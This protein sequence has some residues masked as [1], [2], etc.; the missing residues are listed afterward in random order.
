MLVERD[1]QPATQTVENPF[2][3]VSL[4]ALGL[5][6][7]IRPLHPEDDYAAVLVEADDLL[8]PPWRLLQVQGVD[9]LATGA[10]WATVLA[11]LAIL[12]LSTMRAVAVV[13]AGN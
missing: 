5:R 8:R 1:E 2:R 4:Q 11:Q 9:V 3:S 7:L 10:I 6:S 13:T 12:D